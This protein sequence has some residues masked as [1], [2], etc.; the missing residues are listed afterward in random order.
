MRRIAQFVGL[1]VVLLVLGVGL[2][3][4]A[5]VAARGNG[6]YSKTALSTCPACHQGS[7]AD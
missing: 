2:H 3:Y 4:I 7:L 1:L 5:G 6:P